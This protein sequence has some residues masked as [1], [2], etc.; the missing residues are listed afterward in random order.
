MATKAEN[1]NIIIALAEKGWPTDEI[2]SFIGF[3]ESHEPTEKE[4]MEA[5]EKAKKNGE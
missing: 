4:V 5:V 1:S 3:I 2:V